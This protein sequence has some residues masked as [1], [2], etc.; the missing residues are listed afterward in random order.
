MADFRYDSCIR[1]FHVYKDVWNPVVGETLNA[2]REKT[3]LSINMQFLW[4]RMVTLSDMCLGKTAAFFLKHGGTFRCT[5]TGK[6]RWSGDLDMGGLEIPCFMTFSGPLPLIER[7]KT[8]LG[9]CKGG[10]LFTENW[11]R[12]RGAVIGAGALNRDYTVV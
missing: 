12:P 3:I 7:L 9:N 10:P 8:L 6:H 1:G 5:V 4:W 2:E 11:K